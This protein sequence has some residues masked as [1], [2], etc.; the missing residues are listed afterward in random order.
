MR[1]ITTTMSIQGVAKYNRLY[2]ENMTDLQRDLQRIQYE[3]E[4]ELGTNF[5]TDERLSNG[6]LCVIFMNFGDQLNITDQIRV[7]IVNRVMNLPEE[8]RT[9]TLGELEIYYGTDKYLV[10]ALDVPEPLKQLRNELYSRYSIKDPIKLYDPHITLGTIKHTEEL[11]LPT[12][13]I[14]KREYLV[15]GILF[16]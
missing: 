13:E 6:E 15:R 1:H 8:S 2:L 4:I 7:Y 10:L 12:Y 5:L 14:N 9:L 11:E 16:Y 3:V